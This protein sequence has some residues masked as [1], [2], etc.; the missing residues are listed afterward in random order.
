GPWD[1]PGRI[2]PAAIDRLNDFIGHRPV[3]VLH[4][5]RMEPYKHEWVRPIPLYIEGAGVA[6]GKYHD[7]VAKALEI[8]RET[9]RDILDLAFFELE[10][11]EELA[12]D[13]RAYDFDHPANQRINYQFGQWDP[14]RI[15]NRGLYR[16]FV[17]TQVTI[18]ALLERT[19]S[20]RSIPADE[21]LFEAAAVLAG[22][23]LMASGVSG[24]GPDTHD[25]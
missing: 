9:D 22:T 23:I 21:L 13:P 14:N 7:V 3:A 6:V 18:D 25:S 19:T 16:R 20:T 1:D 12:L 10:R 17:V 11:M 2:I 5:Q 24:R 15:D 8:L 4:N